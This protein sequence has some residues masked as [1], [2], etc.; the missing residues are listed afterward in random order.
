MGREV[1]FANIAFATFA[2]LTD[3]ILQS[4]VFTDDIV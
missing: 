4:R 2:L 1:T 3:L